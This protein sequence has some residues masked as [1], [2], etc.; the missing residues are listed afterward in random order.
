MERL[1]LHARAGGFADRTVPVVG[2]GRRPTLR[3]ADDV[4]RAALSGEDGPARRLA[5]R[6][7]PVI[8][9]VVYGQL[10]RSRGI[11]PLWHV[12]DDFTQ[13]VWV[14]LL[15][16]GGR[17]LLGFDPERG[18]S[19]ESFVAMIASREVIS[20]TRK[21]GARK[22]FG[23]RFPH[24]VNDQLAPAGA[25]A[26]PEAVAAARSQAAALSRRLAQRLPERGLL[27]ARFLYEDLRSPAEVARCLGVDVQVVYNWQHRI[28]NE[29]RAFFG[30]SP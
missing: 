6:L 21:L 24:A 27:I 4:V 19:I 14:S 28:R 16:R 29:A 18:V 25:A 15:A 17:K 11:A 7:M 20:L 8:R 12:V 1:S 26:D 3:E 10:A 2:V 23:D 22:R 13:E 5:A 30:L 9:S